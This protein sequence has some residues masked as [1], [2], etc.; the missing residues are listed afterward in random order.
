MM[1]FFHLYRF[2][3]KKQEK[4]KKELEDKYYEIAAAEMAELNENI[5]PINCDICMEENIE[6]F[7]GVVLKE[8][9]HVFCKYL[10]SK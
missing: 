3:I 10:F 6:P 5:H 9:L 1:I 7:M 4:I 8:C 2:I